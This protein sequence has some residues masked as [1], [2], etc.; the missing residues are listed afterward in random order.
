MTCSMPGGQLCGSMY[1]KFRAAVSFDRDFSAMPKFLAVLRLPARMLG[2]AMFSNGFEGF[3][4][5]LCGP[6]TTNEPTE[7]SSQN[8]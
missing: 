5:A 8:V 4:Y 7:V 3:P 6:Q 2:N 1:C